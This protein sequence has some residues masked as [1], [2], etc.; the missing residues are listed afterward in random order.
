MVTVSGT[1]LE[2]MDAS[3]Y[4]YMRLKTANGATW[5]AV[6]KT[7]V[8]KGDTVTVTNAMVMDGILFGALGGRGGASPAAAAP[9]APPARRQT[10]IHQSKNQ[11]NVS[12]PS[13]G[14]GP[15]VRTL[16]LGHLVRSPIRADL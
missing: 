12:L 4:T 5:A 9:A 7:K 6:A 3:E 13:R 11:L 15:V 14:G 16:A 10:L 8:S 1:I 2:T